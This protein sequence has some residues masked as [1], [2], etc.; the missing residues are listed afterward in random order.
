[1]VYF[2]IY[3]TFAHIVQD[4][5]FT[6]RQHKSKA[7]EAFVI[8][9]NGTVPPS[10]VIFRQWKWSRDGR[11]VSVWAVRQGAGSPG[12][13]RPLETVLQE[14]DF[15]AMALSRRWLHRHQPYLPTDH[16]GCQIWRISLWQGTVTGFLFIIMV[17]NSFEILL[18]N[19][20][21]ENLTLVFSD[22][23]FNKISNV[24]IYFNLYMIYY[25]IKHLF[26]NTPLKMSPI[27][28]WLSINGTAD[29]MESSFLQSQL[30][31]LQKSVSW[32]ACCAFPGW[33]GGTGLSA[34]LHR[35]WLRGSSGAPA[36]PHPLL[37]S[38]QRDQH[39]QDCGEVGSL[40][41]GCA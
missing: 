38:W 39:L 32:L 18:G 19:D 12:E 24:L 21:S 8:S 17:M 10:G 41:H 14:G 34:V 16:Q 4:A 29:I 7:I 36:Q 3:Y 5:Q 25:N 22:A 33:A 9:I 30:P 2:F 15:H 26:L 28:L 20:L 13:E 23:L 27:Q 11:C 37:H 1:M 6:N 35:L 40:H 31:H